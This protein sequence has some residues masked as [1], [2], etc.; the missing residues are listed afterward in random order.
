MLIHRV[1]KTYIKQFL[2]L[3]NLV[4]FSIF[5]AFTQ[6]F[7]SCLQFRMSDKKVAKYFQNK[8]YKPEFHTYQ[9]GKRTMHYVSIG[10]DTLPTVLLIHGSPGAWD[11]FIDYLGDSSMVEKMRLIAV[12]RPG[13]GKSNFGKAERDLAKQAALIKPILE[14]NKSGKSMILVGHSYGGPVIA[15][16]AMDY[17]DLVRG[18]IFLAPSIAPELEKTKW[19]QYPAEWLLINWLLPRGLLVSNREIRHLKEDLEKII[20]YWGNIN[21]PVIYIHG[22]KDSLVPI[23]NA[24]FAHKMLVNA[25]VEM[26]RIPNTDHFI[27]WT[28]EK[29]V[30][31]AIFKAVKEF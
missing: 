15:R 14:T 26:I 16:L 8:Q 28:H 11:A 22:E 21:K 24:D 12:D 25:K 10:A 29:L 2:S 6:M 18:L 30:K 17:P 19:F 4:V 7:S 23:A 20:P 3:K 31:D 9:V 1:F 5:L 13:F 27:P